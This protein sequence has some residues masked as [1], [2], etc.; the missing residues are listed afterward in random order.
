MTVA[1]TAPPGPAVETTA[2]LTAPTT[3]RAPATA[4]ASAAPPQSPVADEGLVQRGGATAPAPVATSAQAYLCELERKRDDGELLRVHDLHIAHGEL[5]KNTGQDGRRDIDHL[6]TGLLNDQPLDPLQRDVDPRSALLNVL[7]AIEVDTLQ[8]KISESLVVE[9]R[10]VAHDARH[11]QAHQAREEKLKIVDLLLLLRLAATE[12]NQVAAAIQPDGAR[13]LH[14][15]NPF[16]IPRVRQ[17]RAED[18]QK[19]QDRGRHAPGG[20]FGGRGLLD[21]EKREVRVVNDV[22]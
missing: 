10:D 16:P 22:A 2:E 14:E 5:L 18:D 6:V 15:R 1:T 12:G 9:A 13:G 8:V 21:D 11:Q 17:A 20:R 7:D 19:S 3:P 4:P